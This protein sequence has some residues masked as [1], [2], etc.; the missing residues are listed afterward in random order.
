M[1]P[2]VFLSSFLSHFSRLAL[3]TNASCVGWAFGVLDKAPGPPFSWVPRE[4]VPGVLKTSFP[5]QVILK[6]F[7]IKQ[8]QKDLLS[9]STMNNESPGVPH[10]RSSNVIVLFHKR[11]A[12]WWQVIFPSN[13][14]VFPGSNLLNTRYLFLYPLLNPRAVSAQPLSAAQRSGSPH[15]MGLCELLVS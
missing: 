9:R 8:K 2:L 7:S 13:S 6:W 4:A 11:G 14:S 3:P 5:L 10:E 1:L 12:F 15:T